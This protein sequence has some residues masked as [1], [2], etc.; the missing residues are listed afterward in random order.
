MWQ[1]H[2]F[3][4]LKRCG[5]ERISNIW[6]DD[7]SIK[8]LQSYAMVKYQKKYRHSRCYTE[9]NVIKV[10]QVKGI[11]VQIKKLFYF[12]RLMFQLTLWLKLI[13]RETVYETMNSYYIM[14]ICFPSPTFWRRQSIP[15]LFKDTR[16]FD[17]L[18]H[19]LLW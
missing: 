5:S 11:L 12:F 17:W 10:D 9:D 13:D 15:L 2:I 14:R 19:A 8:N 1:R 7:W 16:A 6:E 4:T 18:F 3:K